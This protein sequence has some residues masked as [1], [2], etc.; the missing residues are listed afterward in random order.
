MQYFNN[1]QSVAEIKK[2]YRRLANIHHPDKGGD[3]AAMQEL[4]AQYHEALQNIHGSITK[5]SE[6]QE[7][8]YY[9]DHGT[10]EAII[11]KIDELMALRLS[12]IEIALIGTW[13]WITGETKQ[14]KEALKAAKC[15]W[16]GKRK[17]WFFTTR[18]G[19]WNSK[20]SL[21]DLAST[22]GYSTFEGRRQ[23]AITAG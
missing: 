17:C 22:Y 3:T 9:Y 4:N 18:K 20:A 8:T 2:A 6:G 16:H 15:K 14:H 19:K 13:I 10:E 7:H 23:N 21:S 5:D 11:N 1:E 12:D